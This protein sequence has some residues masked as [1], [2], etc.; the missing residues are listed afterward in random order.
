MYV[1]RRILVAAGSK[2]TLCFLRLHLLQARVM[3]D[4]RLAVL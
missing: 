4:F 1:P 2:L 3:R